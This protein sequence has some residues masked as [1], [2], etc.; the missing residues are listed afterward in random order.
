[1]NRSMRVLH[2]FII[3]TVLVIILRAPGFPPAPARPAEFHLE[4]ESPQ[5][6]DLVDR[7]TTLRVVGTGFGFTE[8][9]VWDQAGF[10]YVSERNYQQDLP[11]PS[12][13]Q[14]GGSDCAR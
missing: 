4:A 5:F 7:N 8:G 6:W 2:T 1:M 14:E 9:P 3:A 13:R 10:L 12:R 11:A